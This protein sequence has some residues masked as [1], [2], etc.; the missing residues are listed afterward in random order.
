MKL[1]GI[2]HWRWA[3][4]AVREKQIKL[5]KVKDYSLLRCISILGCVFTDL[6]AKKA[7]GA[8]HQGDNNTELWGLPCRRVSRDRKTKWKYVCERDR[9]RWRAKLVS[10]RRQAPK[11][12]IRTGKS[13]FL[14]L[15]KLPGLMKWRGILYIYFVYAK[16][17]K[18]S[19]EWWVHLT[20]SGWTSET[21]SL[22]QPLWLC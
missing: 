10:S 9:Q 18:Y 7:C 20:S 22:K 4:K 2:S 16:T 8:W 1:F 5:S 13:D 3:G 12:I 19:S 21:E 14:N 17:Q 11:W 6:L 15:L